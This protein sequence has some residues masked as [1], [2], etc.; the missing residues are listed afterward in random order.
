MHVCFTVRADKV[1]DIFDIFK[2]IYIYIYLASCVERY[3]ANG[4][5]QVQAGDRSIHQVGFYEPRH[6][7]IQTFLPGAFDRASPSVLDLATNF[8]MG[9]QLSISDK[10]RMKGFRNK[11]G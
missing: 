3:G 5:V 8:R 10:N 1:F 7:R 4:G 11:I 2:D 6:S 9:L